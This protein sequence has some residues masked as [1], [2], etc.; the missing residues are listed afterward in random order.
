[1]I[2]A[3]GDPSGTW[4]AASTAGEIGTGD[5]ITALVPLPGDNTTGSLAVYGRN[6]TSILYGSGS[7]SWNMSNVAIDSGAIAYTA[8]YVGGALALDD[9]GVTNLRAV[10]AFGN[11]AASSIS[12][13]V[14]P[15]IDDKVGLAVAS[16]VLRSQDQYRVYFTD[17]TALA[18]RPSRDGSAAVMPFTYPNLVTCICSGENTSGTEVVYFGSSN[19]M[20]YQAE[21]GTSF[22]GAA[23]DAW[24]RLAFNSEK[25]PT[26]NKKWRRAIVEMSVP[27]YASLA[28]TYEMDYGDGSLPIVALQSNAQEGGGGYWDEFTWDEF[29][30]DSQIVSL[31]KFALSGT[32]QNISLLFNSNDDISLPFTLQSVVLHYTP[33][34]IKR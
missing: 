9:R 34:R 16:S 11:F 6:K 24:I 13:S 10:Q 23:I 7:A 17:G 1:M 8:Q 26:L 27:S 4:V 5:L 30:W 29:T 31:P 28:F 32:S 12:K 3:P 33:R 19:G 25:G 22:D 15:Y 20:V 2:S 18:F 14:Q 21:R